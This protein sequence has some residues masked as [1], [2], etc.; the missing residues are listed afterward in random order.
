MD[1]RRK[2]VG[3]MGSAPDEIEGGVPLGTIAVELLLHKCEGGPDHV[4]MVNVGTDGLDYIEPDG[5]NLME[6]IGA[7]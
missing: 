6:V 3:R 7:E 5:V 4:T 1:D 2:L